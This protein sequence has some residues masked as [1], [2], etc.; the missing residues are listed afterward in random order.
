[1]ARSTPRF[2]PRTNRGLPLWSRRKH[3]RGLAALRI[4]LDHAGVALQPDDR[5]CAPVA[6][7]QSRCGLG[8]IMYSPI[9]SII[10]S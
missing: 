2:D 7:R 9:G 4:D 3:A 10:P 8:K 1:M 6:P 5:D